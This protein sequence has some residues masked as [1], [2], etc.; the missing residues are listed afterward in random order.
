MFIVRQNYSSAISKII[1]SESAK[2]LVVEQFW[3]EKL[4]FSDRQNYSL[5]ISKIIVSK[6]EKLLI[7]WD[8]FQLQNSAAIGK[9]WENSSIHVEELN[10]FFSFSR[11]SSRRKGVLLVPREFIL[12]RNVAE[13][14]LVRPYRILF[15]TKWIPIFIVHKKRFNTPSEPAHCPGAKRR[16][17]MRAG[18]RN[19]VGN[20]G[21]IFK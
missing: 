3:S 10:I 14:N 17:A 6:S 15:F 8:N 12:L 9:K 19:G 13:K 1:V 21:V 5:A 4:L 11:F 2:L 16:A 20:L 7:F 18:R